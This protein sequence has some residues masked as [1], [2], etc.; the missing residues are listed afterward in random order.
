MKNKILFLLISGLLFVFCAPITH[1][2]SLD[3]TKSLLSD[4]ER[5]ILQALDFYDE[6]NSKNMSRETYLNLIIKIAGLDRLNME[7]AVQAGY[8]DYYDDGSLYPAGNVTY[9]EVITGL[10]TALGYQSQ[11][12][13]AKQGKQAA[14]NLAANLKITS[15]LSLKLTDS[16]SA[17]QF[18]KMVYRSLDLPLMV[19]VTFGEKS[20]KY[21][22]NK[23]RTLLSEIHH[24]YKGRGQVTEN[25]YS[26]FMGNST[27]GKSQVKID[28]T[29]LLETNDTEAEYLLG[30]L[31]EYY[32]QKE[33]GNE[34]ARLIWINADSE[35][36]NE[37]YLDPYQRLDYKDGI[38][39]YDENGKTGTAKLESSAIVLYNGKATSKGALSSAQLSPKLG[40]VTLLDTKQCGSYNI[41]IIMDYTAGLVSYYDQNNSVLYLK[42]SLAIHISE[43][44][45]IKIFDPYFNE[46]GVNQITAGKTVWCAR[47]LDG[48]YVTIMVSENSVQGVVEEIEKTGLNESTGQLYLTVSGKRYQVTPGCETQIL[49]SGNVNLNV[50]ATFYLDIDGNI[51]FASPNSAGNRFA[52]LINA[53]ITKDISN[54]LEL[55]IFDGNVSVLAVAEQV[56]VNGENVNDHNVLFGSLKEGGVEVVTR[57]IRFETNSDGKISALE[58]AESEEPNANG[59]KKLHVAGRIPPERDGQGGVVYKHTG[60][61]F[62]NYFALEANAPVFFIPEDRMDLEGYSIGT[63]ASIP[64]DHTI[65]GITGYKIDQEADACCA[66]VYD[67]NKTA[68]VDGRP[69][70]SEPIIVKQINSA[71]LA[72][73]SIGYRLHYYNLDAQEDYIDIPD[74]EPMLQKMTELKV[75]DII[76]VDRNNDGEIINWTTTPDYNF[77]THT[78]NTELLA[79]DYDA[80]PRISFGTVYRRNTDTVL[81]DSPAKP[82]N[83]IDYELVQF[84]IAKRILIVEYKNDKLFVRLGQSAEIQ[85]NDHLYYTS[86]WGFLNYVLVFK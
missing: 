30:Y 8:L 78:G 80:A 21:I 83:F 50:F 73:E 9:G 25:G 42:N 65:F 31:V 71:V 43:D 39:F 17:E 74:D 19:Q 33:A 67:D 51:T 5:G 38:Y 59:G 13:A 35:E 56:K 79:Y 55:L 32:Y 37:L 6:T 41:A 12:E 75:G 72:D 58:Y 2:A 26:S 27:I 20:Q 66:A 68:S 52:Y 49:D 40:E 53:R 61:I 77:I 63:P 15:A 3:E 1:A 82:K 36:N 84:N 57:L 76:R 4:K 23:D 60:Y 70:S 64:N 47:S 44:A 22:T 48:T 85:P 62:T 10:L 45:D 81:L 29:L 46:L 11:L 34:I 18:G 24:I 7:Q 69:S 14:L 86:G 54:C 16:I 28:G